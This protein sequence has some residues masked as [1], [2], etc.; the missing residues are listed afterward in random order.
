MSNPRSA[1][2]SECVAIIVVSPLHVRALVLEALLHRMGCFCTFLIEFASENLRSFDRNRAQD[3]GYYA[4]R[5]RKFLL[6]GQVIGMLRLVGRVTR[7]FG[8]TPLH[9]KGG[10]TFLQRRGTRL[11][12]RI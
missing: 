11:E 5:R 10:S 8:Q 6:M 4:K 2:G 7:D 12:E 3:S 9:L 1:Q